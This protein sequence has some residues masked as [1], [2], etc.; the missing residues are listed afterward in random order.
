MNLNKLIFLTPFFVFD[1]RPLELPPDPAP[2]VQS[3]ILSDAN[4]SKLDFQRAKVSMIVDAVYHDVLKGHYVLSPEILMDER[5]VSFR[6][7]GPSV[8]GDLE[9]MLEMLGY[10]I[11]RENNVDLIGPKDKDEL[12]IHSSENSDFDV[13]VYRPNFR[14]VDYLVTVLS[15]F[16]KNNGRF[17]SDGAISAVEGAKVTSSV[18]STSAA[19]LVDKSSDVLIYEGMPDNI[20]KLKRY[21]SQV[22][23]RSGEVVIRGYVF[24]VQDTKDDGSAF[25]LAAST[26]SDKLSLAIG[27]SSSLDNFLSFKSGNLSTVVSAL[28]TDSHFN[29]VSAPELRVK[30]GSEGSFQVGQDVP[31]LSTVSYQGDTPVQSIEYKSSGIIFKCKPIVFGSSTDLTITQTLSNFIATTS[32]VTGSPTLTK[33]DITTTLQLKDGEVVLIGGLGEDKSSDST[34]GFSF[35]PKWTHSNTKSK[36]KTQIIMIL[37]LKVV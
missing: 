7:N 36:T 27:P 30:S 9:R 5:I 6:F 26:I 12:Q 20:K 24:E 35:L 37:Q 18:P 25:R 3:S 22:D 15:P 29:V 8:R 28:A 17:M 14:S 2:F 21:L 13:F 16:F 23:V 34:D 19:A 11:R 10:Q 31:V 33:R 4:S 32:G 1:V